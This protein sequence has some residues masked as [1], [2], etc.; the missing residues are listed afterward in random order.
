MHS[1]DMALEGEKGLFAW[2]AS[3]WL[4]YI[5]QIPKELKEDYINEVVALFV[6]NKCSR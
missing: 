5:Q 6:R 1:E 2:I 4:L 3:T